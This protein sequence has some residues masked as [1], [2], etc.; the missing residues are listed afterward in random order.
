M[1]NLSFYILG[2]YLGYIIGFP[3][4]GLFFIS[5]VTITYFFFIFYILIYEI[6]R[7]TFYFLRST[8]ISVSNRKFNDIQSLLTYLKTEIFKNV[9]I[10]LLI[11]FLLL[12]C[13][14][15]STR[16]TYFFGRDG[17]YHIYLIKIISNYGILPLEEYF[18]AVGLQLFG[19][20]IHF[21]SGSEPIYI[22][23]YFPFYTFFVSALIYYNILKKVFRNKNIIIFGVFLLESSS[24]GFM[25]T[26][27]Q[28]W[29]T[30]LTSIICLMIFYLLYVRLL[31]L[32]KLERPSNKAILN[33]IWF[34]YIL[35]IIM[36]TASLLIHSLNSVIMI[37]PLL[38]V[39]VMYFL[40]DYKRGID[41][42]LLL[43][44]MGIFLILSTFGL[45]EHFL[46]LEGL[47]IEWYHIAIGG[48]GA[49]IILYRMGKTI[50]FTSGRYQM[51]LQGDKKGYYKVMEEKIILPLLGGIV[52]FSVFMFLVLNVLFLDINLSNGFVVIEI[53]IFVYIAVWGLIVFQKKPRG[54]FIFLWILGYAVVYLIG[55]FTD[56]L[57]SR[58]YFSSRIL[59]YTAP[60]VVIGFLSY[61]YKL[62]KLNSIRM[63]KF[64]III[65]S[66]IV[67]SFFARFY[68]ELFDID[69]LEYSATNREVYS[70]LW[71][72]KY[73]TPGKVVIA[74]FGIP[75]LFMYFDYP[76]DNPQYIIKGIHIHYF[77][78]NYS[79][80]FPPFNH[81]DE[82]GQN[83]LKLVKEENKTDVYLIL[84]DN[85]ELLWGFDPIQRLNELQLEL[86]YNMD[87]L[88]K[89]LSSKSES[90]D[91]IPF[92]WVI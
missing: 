71:A 64:K 75:Y 83:I 78:E 25:Y 34:S 37:L 3:I 1:I 31:D 30:N 16:Y 9:N 76:F 87:Y 4:T 92:F 86:Y 18:S 88:N 24:I 67:F 73:T 90:G 65:I 82:L 32:I 55:A 81:F 17:W 45:S 7:K 15:Y 66:I 26:M 70:I 19:A 22:A 72:S 54:K 38:F 63:V 35:I 74:E 62:I 84:D 8:D 12:T 77:P 5:I 23:R 46:L 61:I 68:D 57:A 2:G 41:F 40:K 20:V 14:L 56:Y 11:I 79:V 52:I 48:I 59:L 10:L 39:Y 60:V 51:V 50:H 36:F 89:I 27:Y 28:F 43:V 91:E 44:L 6:K 33:N 69:N 53:I 58:G 21:F 49:F 42:L 13:I 29:P 47:P 80:F 85:F